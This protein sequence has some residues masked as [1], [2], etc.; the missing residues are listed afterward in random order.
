MPDIGLSAK[1]VIFGDMSRYVI[2]QVNGTRFERSD[3]FKFDTDVVS[4]RVAARLD[5]AL[6]DV[7]GVKAFVGK[8]S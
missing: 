1:S 6:I 3:D 8:S 7:N 4:F 5:G 2:R